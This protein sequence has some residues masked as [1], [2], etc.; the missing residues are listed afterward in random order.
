MKH[1]K[2]LVLLLAFCVAFAMMPMMAFAEEMDI[3]IASAEKTN[4]IVILGTSDVH[5]GIEDGLGYAGIAQVV[6]DAKATNDYVAVV[7]AG[8]AIQGGV[9]GTLSKGEYI[10]E[11]MKDT[12]NNEKLLPSC[13]GL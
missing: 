3:A 4:D 6:K 13:I 9:V 10:V 8:D 11:I 7:D 1:N 2:L 12:I 5:C